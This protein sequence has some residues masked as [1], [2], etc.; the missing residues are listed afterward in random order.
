MAPSDIGALTEKLLRSPSPLPLPA[1]TRGEGA[2]VG[3]RVPL[4]SEGSMNRA[5][6][7]TRDEGVGA[8]MP[9]PSSPQRA[10]GRSGRGPLVV[11]AC[12]RVPRANSILL[13]ALVSSDGL[14]TRRNNVREGHRDGQDPRA[15][16]LG[17]LDESSPYTDV[18]RGSR[19]PN[20]APLISTASG[21]TE[22]KGPARCSGA[23]PH[24]NLLPAPRGEGAE[25]GD[26]RAPIEPR[27]SPAR[28]GPPTRRRP[29]RRRCPV[30]RARRGSTHPRRQDPW[31]R[32]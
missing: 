18:R 9:L 22:R 2:E 14:R 32:A 30:P 27:G 13:Q 12:S 24:P 3:T 1:R 5:P 16:R 26:P 7:R 28:A 25:S 20:A 17:G 29:R 19:S 6:T 21:W 11:P 31:P 8:P 10:G 15:P 23:P 4:D